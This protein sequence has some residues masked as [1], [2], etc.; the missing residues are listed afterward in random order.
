MAFAALP[1]C[2]SKVVVGCSRAEEVATTLVSRSRH[3]P[4]SATFGV[5]FTM[6][7]GL[8]GPIVGWFYPGLPTGVGKVSELNCA[9]SAHM[10]RGS[11]YFTVGCAGV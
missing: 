10:A 2:V 6:L 11:V 5:L 9:G 8:D 3:Y 7:C 1:A 4:M